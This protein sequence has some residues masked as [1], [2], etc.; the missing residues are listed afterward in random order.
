MN[1]W[2]SSQF[3]INL[4]S[5]KIYNSMSSATNGGSGILFY[6]SVK[7]VTTLMQL[8]IKLFNSEMNFF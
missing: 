8:L 4:T 2:L 6:Q 3:K 1:D 7:Q 5:N